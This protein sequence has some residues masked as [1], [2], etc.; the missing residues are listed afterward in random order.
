M[1]E[2]RISADEINAVLARHVAELATE[3]GAE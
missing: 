3:V 2:L 1:A